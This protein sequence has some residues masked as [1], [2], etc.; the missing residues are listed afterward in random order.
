MQGSFDFRGWG[1]ARKGAGRK[2]GRNA[3]HVARPPLSKHHPVL[4][5]LRLARDVGNARRK[6]VF[7]TIRDAF[8]AGRERFGF[9]LVHPA[10][11]LRAGPIC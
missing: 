6:S 1:G 5:T 4:V 3:Q 7:K 2:R 11:V 8:K 10:R 9:R